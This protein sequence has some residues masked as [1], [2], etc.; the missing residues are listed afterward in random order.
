MPLVAFAR[1]TRAGD[2]LPLVAFAKLI[3]AGAALPFVA[4]AKL[5]LPACILPAVCR[6]GKAMALEVDWCGK[7]AAGRG[8][9]S[10]CLAC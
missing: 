4:L 8:W 5:I 6:A 2:A 10:P 7:A 3:R 9:F 1:L